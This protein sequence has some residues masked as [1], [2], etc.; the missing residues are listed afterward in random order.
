MA[1]RSLCLALALAGC[2]P[3]PLGV[4]S[5]HVTLAAPPILRVSDAVGVPSGEFAAGTGAIDVDVVEGLG[6]IAAS[7]LPPLPEEFAYTAVLAFAPDARDGLPGE[8]VDRSTWTEVDTDALGKVGATSY[9][10]AFTASDVGDRDLGALRAARV[11]VSPAS[12]DADATVLDG[13][14]DFTAGPAAAEEPAGHTHGA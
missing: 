2:D 11:I 5:V 10:A 14:V 4:L 6:Q 13:E 9:A 3:E 8:V 7:D 1:K 12:D